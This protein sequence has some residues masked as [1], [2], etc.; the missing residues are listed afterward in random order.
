LIYA[1]ARGAVH[2]DLNL[3]NIFVTGSGE[4]RVM[5][6]GTSHK[7]RQTARAPDPEMTLPF[8]ASTYASCQVLEG[9][10]ADARDD[11]FSL[12]CVAYFLLSGSHPFP[13]STAI[14]AREAKLRLRRPGRVS[15][16]Q[17]RALRSAL[18]W[19][20]EN[21]PDDVQR[22]LAQL[23]LSGAAKK[24]VPLND[25]L[26]PPPAKEPTSWIAAG[27]AA[28]VAVLLFAAYWLVS[29]RDLL[30]SID[31]T[32]SI[33]APATAPVP[34]TAAPTAAPPAAAPAAAAPPITA[35]TTSRPPLG[36][37]AKPPSSAAVLPSAPIAAPASHKTPLTATAPAAAPAATPPRGIAPAV[38]SAAKAPAGASKVELAVDTVDVPAGQPSAQVAVHRKGNLRGETSFTWWTESGTA[39]PGADF[40][41]VAPQLAYVADG[42]SGV[43]LS[44]PLSVAPHAQAKSFY[45]VIDQSEGGAPLGARTLTMV[46]LLPS[47]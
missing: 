36:D 13:K 26:E 33:R 47:D 34:V 41:A 18:R 35:P 32:A 27:I 14:E 16:R 6:F 17:W 20:R 8:S 1:H 15:G 23:D 39:K 43:S 45:V 4:V 3:Q 21:R 44:I 10:R 30:P 5:S 12:A 46:T 42:K 31:S 9:E 7:T 22:W 40:S 24:L 37:R 28:G 29:H 11:V 19:E 25:L 2:G 38:A